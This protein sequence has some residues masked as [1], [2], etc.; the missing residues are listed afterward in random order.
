MSRDAGNRAKQASDYAVSTAKGYGADASSLSGQLTPIYTSWAT[1]P[2]GFTQ[3]EQN[4]MNTQNMQSSGGSVAGAVGQGNLQAERT[5]NAGGYQAALRDAA[6][7]GI[8][9]N[10]DEALTVKNANTMYKEAQRQA[11]VA[12]LTGLRA[13]DVGAQLGAMGN[14]VGAINAESNAGRSGWFQN[15]LGLMNALKPSYSKKGGIG[16]GGQT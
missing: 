9:Q 7:R 16:V 5:G 8:A 2:H 11:G 6:R 10:A 15:M 3:Q 1:N 4:D 13:E 12:G 14:N